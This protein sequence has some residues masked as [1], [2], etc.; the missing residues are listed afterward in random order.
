MEY[1]S[2]RCNS[3]FRTEMAAITRPGA[4]PADAPL[5]DTTLIGRP[6]SSADQ[7]DAA[8]PDN[9]ILVT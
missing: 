6:H 9:R 4:L 7:K 5:T 1:Y 2:S 3:M 8:A